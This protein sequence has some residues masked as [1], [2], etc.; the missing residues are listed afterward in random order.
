[1]K[2]AD[3]SPVLVTLWGRFGG[4]ANISPGVRR[5]FFDRVA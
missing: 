1:M 5:D 4:M 2:F 3:V